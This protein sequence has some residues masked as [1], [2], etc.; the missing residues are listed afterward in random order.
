VF[1]NGMM[2]KLCA[3]KS[4]EVG[5]TLGWRKL[6]CQGLHDLLTP[7]HLTKTITPMRMSSNTD[8]VQWGQKKN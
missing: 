7:S 4:C 1:E 2:W 3:R 5:L 8:V 6:L